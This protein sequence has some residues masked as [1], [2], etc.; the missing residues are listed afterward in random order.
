MV[1]MCV[2][3]VYRCRH[4]AQVSMDGVHTGVFV[5]YT[6]VCIVYKCAEMVVEV[7]YMCACRDD[8][9]LGREGVQ[10]CRDGE[11]ASR[12]GVQVYR[13]SV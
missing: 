5:R 10:V 13:D 9:H 8:V 7:V 4:C 3:M 1:Y 6:G 11:Q 2:E 12:D